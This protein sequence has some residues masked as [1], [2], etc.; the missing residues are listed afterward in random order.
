V[1]ETY[2][3]LFTRHDVLLSPTLAH[4]TPE[5]GW[6]SPPVEFDVLRARLLDYVAFTP[7]CNV[8]GA[9]AVSLP[10]GGAANGLP[11]GAHL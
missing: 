8:A 10:A 11:I 2:A 1:R 9:P 6:L 4:V 7:L 5:I 3:D